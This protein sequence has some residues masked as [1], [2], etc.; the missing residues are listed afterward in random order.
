MTKKEVMDTVIPEYFVLAGVLYDEGDMYQLV[1]IREDLIGEHYLI[2][3][4]KKLNEKFKCEGAQLEI[5]PGAQ[6]RWASKK[7]PYGILIR[8]QLYVFSQSWG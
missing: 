7:Y 4:T 1:W 2:C 3:L 8:H 6:R 5:V